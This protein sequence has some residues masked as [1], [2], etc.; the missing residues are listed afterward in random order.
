MK[1][2]Y[3]ALISIFPHFIV[4]SVT[5]AGSV[6]R[7]DSLLGLMTLEEKVGQ[8]SLVDLGVIAR[9]GI[10][11]LI[12][13]QQ[14]DT[15]KLRTAIQRYHVGAVLN[16][17]C[18]SGTIGLERWHE[19]LS[20]IQEQNLCL[21]RLPIPV[22]YGIDA[23]HGANYTKGATLFPQPIGQAAT[24]HPELVE[25]LNA[26]TAYEVRATGI[27]WNFSPVL[28]LARQPLWSR[29][30]ETYG[31]DVL[32]SGTM[33][34]AAVR[35]LQG[36]DVND[37]CRVAACL[38]HFLGYGFPLSGHDRTPVWMSDRELR[39]YF[40]P[41]FEAAIRDGAKSIMVNSGEINGTPVHAN[42]DLLIR[43][44]REELG[45]RGVVVTDWEDI[46]K[47]VTIHHV[48]A[49]RKE[50]VKLAILSGIDMSMTPN[51]FEFNDLLLELVHEGSVP[52]SRIDSSVR[53]VLQLKEELGLFEMK[54]S[55]PLDY[56]RFA[57]TAAVA[58]NYKVAAESMTLLKNNDQVLPL[59][60]VK[61]K[62]FVC[63]PAAHSLNLLNGGWTHTWQGVDPRFNTPGKSTILEAVSKAGPVT[64]H[65]G[66][67]TDSLLDIMACLR[68]ARQ[69]DKIVV[70]LGETPATEV[71]GNIDD[72][73]LPEAQSTLVIRL[74]E[75]GK[76]I[77]LVCC[78]NRPRII[79]A[80]SNNVAAI[81]YAYLP[82]DEG[83]RAIADVLTGRINPS[84]RLPFT[85]P[86]AAN[87]L[88]HYDRKHSEDLDVDFSFKAYR[89][90]FDFGAG[91][92]YTR[93][94]YSGL[95]VDD[96]LLQDADSVTV[97][98]TVE[99][100][101]NRYGEE[102]VQMYYH[103]RVAS[104]TPAVRKLVAF[105][106]TG[107]EPGKKERVRFVLYKKDFSF[108]DRQLHRVTEPGEVDLMAGP[109]QTTIHVQ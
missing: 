70:C 39:E 30:F 58:L 20:T 52:V 44:L 90:E 100:R 105:R 108:I 109:L 75:L 51:D 35:G 63:G 22:L 4:P 21:S 54:K 29:F 53:R 11:D 74:A 14:I 43:L 3:I 23:I 66:S 28:D 32:L 96:S 33:G 9:G 1:R 93:F 77:I 64:H 49:T 61:E 68:M 48:V 107:L 84:G 73:T 46:Y 106:R 16:V 56:P 94:E 36:Q 19:L 15:A 99:N 38:K 18:G 72:L 17:G 55:R 8:L 103:D 12:Q 6:S 25:Q 37:P 5:F 57:D 45:F 92:S 34:K 65:P 7:I 83:G 42:P 10:C 62:I 47:L 76:P 69:A 31:E 60:P 13:P 85:Y 27:P 81:L 102:V 91:L 26:V 101:G 89:P 50:A 87:A 71:P 59:D 41:A 88:V 97:E 98:L 40:L 104:I 24:W 78:F 80:I 67:T 82:G 95:S 2:F 86:A 79:H